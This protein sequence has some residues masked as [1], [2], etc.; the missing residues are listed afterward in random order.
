MADEPQLPSPGDVLAGKYR[1]ERLIGQGG[2]GAVFA[3]E[4]MLLNQRVAV[5]LLL[6]EL[7]T[8]GEA[9]ARFMNEARAAARIHGEHVARVLDIGQLPT[10]APYMV[11][12]YLEGADLA[13]IRQRRG[14]LT[15]PEV[16]DYMLQALDALAQAHAA[17]IVHRDLKPA[18][19]FLAKRHDGTNVVKVLDFGISK[20]LTPFGSSPQGMTNTRAILGSPEYMSPEQLRTPRSVDARTDI[21]SHRRHPVRALDGHDAVRGR[22]DRRA[23]HADHGAQPAAVAVIPRRHP[24]GA[25]R[26]RVAL[27]GARPERSIPERSGAR[28]D[29][30]DVRV[31]GN[32]RDSRRADV[33]ARH[34]DRAGR[35]R[36]WRGR[37]PWSRSR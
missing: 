35:R 13:Q 9:Q 19:L 21:W 33:V 30:A 10:G 18:N 23:F 12:E 37:C 1:I 29:S 15:V 24:G 7:V 28:G 17:G 20:N 3:A 5:K 22:V 25:R 32:A 16:A 31:G 4:H 6:G 14:T 11:L 26:R 36:S 8:S 2:M 34:R 27:P